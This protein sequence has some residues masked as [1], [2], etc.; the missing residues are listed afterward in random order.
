MAINLD[1]ESVIGHAGSTSGILTYE[2][3]YRERPHYNPPFDLER[4]IHGLRIFFYGAGLE[5]IE[6]RFEQFLGKHPTTGAEGDFDLWT[7]RFNGKL[8]GASPLSQM[9]LNEARDNWWREKL[10]SASERIQELE[11]ELKGS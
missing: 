6:V 11:E 10:K 3:E 9:A 7:V 1:Y 2:R 4:A 8:Y 5:H